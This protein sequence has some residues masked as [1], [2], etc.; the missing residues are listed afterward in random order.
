MAKLP[1]VTG[2]GER[3]TPSAARPIM[4]NSVAGR[5]VSQA[6]NIL[7]ND[8]NNSAAGVMALTRG[9]SEAAAVIETVKARA[10]NRDDAVATAN[11]YSSY[12]T[13]GNDL[14]LKS[15]TESDWADPA[16]RESFVKG[17]NGLQ[18]SLVSS[19][20]GSPDG[21]AN[22]QSFISRQRTDFI[23]H[24]A[25]Q[26][27]TASVNKT[28]RIFGDTIS[29]LS[30][31]AYER[32][33]EIL[34]LMNEGRVRAE[35]LR[36][37]VG[38]DAEAEH[39][40]NLDSALTE[41]ALS[42]FL[43]RGAWKEAL[44]FLDKTD[45][46]SVLD[47]G[48]RLRVNRTITQ[49]RQTDAQ[50]QAKLMTQDI[51]GIP[52]DEWNKLPHDTQI[53]ILEGGGPVVNINQTQES[54][55]AKQFG[56]DEAKL[57]TDL[58][59]SSLTARQTKTSLKQMRSALEGG[60]F[61][62]GAASGIRKTAATFAALIGIPG[63]QISPLIG[64]AASA[65][66]IDQA[67]NAL[68]I[69]LSKEGEGRMTNLFLRNIADSL[70]NL[71]RTPEGNKIIVDIMDRVADRQIEMAQLAEK[72]SREKKGLT[73]EKGPSFFDALDK[74]EENKPVIDDALAKRITEASNAGSGIGIDGFKRMLGEAMTPPKD[75]EIPKGFEYDGEAADGS[76]YVLKRTA[77]GA[78]KV[79]PRKPSK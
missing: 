65:E 19:Y 20:S 76:G 24:A 8:A 38:A 44:D 18:E 30:N 14:F 77:D 37:A 33:G 68:A 46:D 49:L 40:A 2:L 43:D 36:G 27:A 75:I 73:P 12:R 60:Q 56:Q 51:K 48:A 11:A 32:P 3:P 28:K 7:T 35:P 66:T 15:L 9:A 31:R 72:F 64:S 59:Q 21:L 67:F 22:L 13:Q 47:Q 70:P 25:T 53:R 62:T 23:S 34:S 50:A 79:I 39:M 4:D 52:R 6:A 16:T 61:V 29:E 74:L 17:L 5:G 26:A 63:E 71:A 57:V 10:Q 78:K 45:A 55:F 58:R 69:Q 41:A 42:H 1:D 54:S